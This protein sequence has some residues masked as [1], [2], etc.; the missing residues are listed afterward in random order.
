MAGTGRRRIGGYELLEQI[1]HGG[2]AVVYRAADAAGRDVAIKVIAGG[3]AADETFRARFRQEAELA[4]QLRHP[5]I[6]AVIESGEAVP[7]GAGP[8]ASPE[9][10]AYLVMEYMAGGNLTGLLAAPRDA[11]QRCLLALAVAQQIGAALDWAHGAGVLHRDVKP[12]N[13]LV[14]S[15][16][17]FVLGDFGLARVLQAGISLHLTATG[18]VAGTPAYMAP[19]Q[20]MGR[21][22]DPRTDIYALGVVL[23]EILTGR[24]PFDAETPMAV[25]LAHVHQPPPPPCQIAPDLPE[26]LQDV[27]LRAL[28]KAP[29]DRF[30]SAG[31][32]ATA[33]RAAVVQAFGEAAIDTGTFPAL[34]TCTR[35]QHLV[36]RAPA[37]TPLRRTSS[38]GNAPSPASSPSAPP[39]PVTTARGSG[40]RAVSLLD[41]LVA[42]ALALLAAVSLAAGGGLV[43]A[44][45][46][47]RPVLAGLLAGWLADRVPPG[48]SEAW[49]R[50]NARKVDLKPTIMVRFTKAM[51]QGSVQEAFR[52]EN[53]ATQETVPVE[54]NWEGLLLVVVPLQELEP[55]TVYQWSIG[56]SAQDVDGRPLGEAL[57]R[58]LTTVPLAQAPASQGV[59][60]AA[61]PVER[62]SADAGA[63]PPAAER[64]QPVA[65][66]ARP[67]EPRP[68]PPTAT[69]ALPPTRYPP[70]T[71]P[72]LAP[73][74]ALVAGLVVN[75]DGSSAVLG[76]EDA[77][78]SPLTP[79]PD[80]LSCLCTPTARSED[81]GGGP[82]TP[83]PSSP[84]AAT[85]APPA[86]ATPV[87]APATT[88]VAGATETAEARR[89]SAAG[90]PSWTASPAPTASPSATAMPSVTVS[91]ARPATATVVPP[92]ATATAAMQGTATA[93]SSTPSPGASPPAG[94]SPTAPAQSTAPPRPSATST[95]A[96][97]TSPGQ[98]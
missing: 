23:Y 74:Q 92:A 31:E 72:A 46:P 61:P 63:P 50:D 54:F 84:P 22:A 6:L 65:T 91:P 18:L 21:P 55:S 14:A 43:V 59:A 26:P 51:D 57:R 52:L 38:A 13:V 80:A 70:P 89:T 62:A 75:P 29:D 12:S 3:Y 86:P 95:A 93:A 1:G 35:P 41:R 68:P 33:L 71:A 85:P 7:E 5:H 53:V 4:A 44:L 58:R 67:A 2:S 39:T 88:R 42:L 78:G 30:A 11:R 94:A 98:I 15:D 8:F 47:G 83:S 56:E 17:R 60:V 82:P 79:S 97:Q 10:V 66:A 34:P 81:A 27:I 49:P 19:E 73:D 76:N 9:T 20:A 40:R 64:P 25:M 87:P 96:S 90:T 24:V 48:V 36:L 32:L 28:A 37:G 16:G 69:P 45:G 77:G